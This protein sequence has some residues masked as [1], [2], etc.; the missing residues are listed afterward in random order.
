MTNE[1]VKKDSLIVDF[2]CDSLGI[3]KSHL[4]DVK[5][6]DVSIIMGG[7]IRA[8]YTKQNGQTSCISVRQTSNCNFL[9]RS[10]TN[11]VL[12]KKHFI[13]DIAILRNEGKT[14]KEISECLGI[15][16]AY[17]SKLLKENPNGEK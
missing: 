7:E 3:N 13:D 5:K 10:V 6:I 1:I 16:Q 11:P 9:E 12:R 2:L 14:Q 17:V 15:S 4:D 8:V